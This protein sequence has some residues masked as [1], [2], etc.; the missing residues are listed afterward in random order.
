MGH[1]LEGKN[2]L[3][4]EQILFCKNSA[5]TEK[6]DKNDDSSNAAHGVVHVLI[7]LSPL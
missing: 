5:L 3:I 2:L 7:L 1:S 6:R 4:G